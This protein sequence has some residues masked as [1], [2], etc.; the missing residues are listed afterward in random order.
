MSYSSASEG[1]IVESDGETKATTT[2]PSLKDGAIDRNDRPRTLVSRSARPP[3]LDGAYDERESGLDY[4]GRPHGQ[5]RRYEDD[6][7]HDRDSSD[8]RRF[9]VHYEGGRPSGN[10]SDRSRGSEN[11]GKRPQQY[12]RR[13]R[14]RSPNR[15]PGNRNGHDQGGSPRNYNYRGARGNDRGEHRDRYSGSFRDN[16]RGQYDARSRRSSSSNFSRESTPLHVRQNLGDTEKRRS[17][18]Q[19]DSLP[20]CSE[21]ESVKPTGCAPLVRKLLISTLTPSSAAATLAESTG[22]EEETQ[23]LDEAAQIEARRKR[24]EALRAKHKNQETPLLHKALHVDT[25]A[26]DAASVKDGEIKADQTDAPSNASSP[27]TPQLDSLGSPATISVDNDED[28][29]HRT[30]DPEEGPSAADYDPSMDVEEKKPRGQQMLQ[31]DET[32]AATYDETKDND[33]EIILQQPAQQSDQVKPAKAKEFDMFAED[34]DDDDDMF[35]PEDP[36]KGHKKDDG[37][38]AVRIPEAKQLDKSLLDDWD[39]PEGYYRIILG[40]LLDGR[41]HVQTNLGKGVFSAVVRALDAKTDK[42]VAI[43]VIRKQESMYRAGMQESATLEKL[44][45]TDPEDKKHVIRLERH[46]EH[47]GHLCMVFENLSSNLREVLKKFG[48]DVG[49]NIKAV[50][51]YAQQMFLGLG[52]L[53]KCEILHADLKPDN[54]LVNESRSHLKI[55]DLGSA[56][57]IEDNEMTDMLVSRFY[58]APEIMLG[59]KNDYAIDMWSVGCTLFELYT[60]KICFTGPSNNQ[61]LKGIMECRGKIPNRML[62]KSEYWPQHFEP[63]GTFLSQEV[64]SVTHKDVLRKMNITR[65]IPAKELK[66]RLFANAKGLSPADAKELTLFAD[67][68]DK[69]LAVDPARRIT[70]NEAL[71]HGFINRSIPTTRT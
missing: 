58:R 30:Q 46:F 7:Y 16:S 24:R 26:P 20:V 56:I 64:D 54:V 49:I 65:T 38:Q 53:K 2:Q 40:E 6:A 60:G 29:L 36:T 18:I 1:E 42:L 37:T 10:Y 9:K 47:K 69:C 41:Y 51:S 5:K 13:N 4:D 55:A 52:L 14:S 32:T 25:T 27:S 57:G 23:V 34:D 61:M 21:E 3:Q 45:E 71:K 12:D 62:K 44:A 22:A 8:T 39:D 59:I 48:R 67:L 31:G 63:D 33:R 15:Q 35:A 66:S 11:R 19:E 68:L 28:L 43:K 50:R 17:P 70:P